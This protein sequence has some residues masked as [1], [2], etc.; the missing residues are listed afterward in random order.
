[1]LHCTGPDGGYG[2]WMTSIECQMIEGGTADIL[3]LGNKER[4]YKLTT[5]VEYRET[6][7]KGGKQPYFKKDGEKKE[8]TGGRINWWG[9]DPMWSDDLGFR[10]KDDLEKP[11]GEWNKLECICA[12]DSIT[13]IVNGTVANQAANVN[14]HKGKILFQSEGAEVFFRKIE[15]H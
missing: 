14:P 7:P 1:L 6:G 15:L 13:L 4:P 3:V 5:T 10:G 12:G 11:I 9:R 2:P 8:F